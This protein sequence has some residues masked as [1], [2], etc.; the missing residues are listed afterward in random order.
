MRIAQV[1]P[2]HE[3]VPP[4]LY[5]GT[6]RVVCYL[7]EELVRRG[8]EVTLFASGDSHTAARLRPMCPNALRLAQCVDPL[9]HHVLMIEKIMQES[10][11]FDVIHF[12]TDFLHFPAFRRHSTPT[13]GTLH[14]RLDLPDL[15][16]LYHEFRDVPVVSIS[17]AQRL[18]LLWLNWRST[19]HHGLPG[20]LLRFQPE[21]GRYLAFLGR[22]CPEKR[23]DL[24]VRIARALGMELKVAAKVDRADLK[25]YETIIKPLFDDP[26]VEFVGEI[27]EEEKSEFLGGAR[28]L[29]FPIDWPEPFGLTLIES[30][31][32]GTPVIAFR[33]GSVPEIVDDGLTGFVVEDCAQAVMAFEQIGRLDRRAVRGTFEERFSVERMAE[34][35][36]AIYENL[37]ARSLAPA[38][39]A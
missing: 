36:L 6:E 25:Y 14:G 33:C 37:T 18:P 38:R 31:A 34:D 12:H 16:P 8:H 39:I 32:C 13:V 30:M 7:T 24:A 4:R 35:Y 9:P 5:G 10:D 22:I 19:V 28:A 23:P 1:A 21:P 15:V 3:S 27:A 29:L 2:L 11:D 26:L 17:D 20:D